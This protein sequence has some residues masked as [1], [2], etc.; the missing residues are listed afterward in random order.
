MRVVNL[1]IGHGKTGSSFLQSALA[2]TVD[3]LAEHK[4]AYPDMTNSFANARAGKITSGNAHI[5]QRSLLEYVREA[6]QAAASADSLLF[7]NEGLFG[8]LLQGSSRAVFAR[9][10]EEGFKLRVLLYIRDPLDHAI[11]LYQQTV[12]R[13]GNTQYPNEYLASYTAPRE[14]GR[15]IKQLRE[16][17]IE[18]QISNYTRH[19]KRILAVAESWLGLGEGFLNAPTNSMVNR[20][21]SNAELVLQREFNKHLG[22]RSSSLISDPLCNQLPNVKSEYPAV[23]REDLEVFL[24]RMQIMINA[25]NTDL[26]TDER[27]RVPSIDEA[28]GRFSS[29]SDAQKLVFTQE[30]IEVIA[31]RISK[32]VSFDT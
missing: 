9:L 18:L 27:Y 6:D 26:P 14:V 3:S 21:M 13:S 12:K 2:L 22:R 11:S 20:S 4:I 7:S 17:D 10:A 30:Q 32:N 29:P 15:V 1:H 25:V 23:G 16:H 19:K 24:D 8:Y 28:V 5:N 31:K